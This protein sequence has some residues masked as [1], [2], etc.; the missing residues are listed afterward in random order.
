MFIGDHFKFIII[1]NHI[2]GFHHS[3]YAF[4]IHTVRL[5]INEIPQ[6][7]VFVTLRI[8]LS[9]FLLI[10]KYISNTPK[11]MKISH[12]WLALPPY[13]I[14]SNLGTLLH[15]YP[16]ANLTHNIHCF[17]LKVIR[18]IF[19]MKYNSS[20]FLQGMILLLNN[21]ILLR[22]DGSRKVMSCPFSIAKGT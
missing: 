15:F 17:C 14:M 21:V 11:N 2:Y 22:C 3:F 13:F 10:S 19:G 9:S 20:H 5:V 12:I 8:K 16:L 1:N 18:N 6:E 7:D 4:M